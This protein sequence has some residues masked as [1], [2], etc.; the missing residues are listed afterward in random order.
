[1]E[2]VSP[3]NVLFDELRGWT[4][5]QSTPCRTPSRRS[6]VAESVHGKIIDAESSRIQLFAEVIQ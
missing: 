3:L 1:M 2:L 5:L 6:F 4:A